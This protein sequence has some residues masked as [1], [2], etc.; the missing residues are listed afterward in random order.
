MSG[1]TAGYSRHCLDIVLQAIEVLAPTRVLSLP[2]WGAL[3]CDTAM[4]EHTASF[5]AR[6]MPPLLV[7]APHHRDAPG[8]GPWWSIVPI[9]PRQGAAVVPTSVVA[10]WAPLLLSCAHGRRPAG[11]AV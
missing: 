8:L 7:A 5:S 9:V 2:G 6:G 1:W 11:P 3:V 4:L 10:D